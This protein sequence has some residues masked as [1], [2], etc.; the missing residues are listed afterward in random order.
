MYALGDV[1]FDVLKDAI[2]KPAMRQVLCTASLIFN[3]DFESDKVVYRPAYS[4][5]EL[6]ATK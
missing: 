1:P 2:G 3:Y 4:Q 5:P 6:L